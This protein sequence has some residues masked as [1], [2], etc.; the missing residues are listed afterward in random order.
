MATDLCTLDR[1]ALRRQ[2]HLSLA[3]QSKK[4][5]GSSLRP[6]EAHRECSDEIQFH[7]LF[8]C[9]MYISLPRPLPEHPM[10]QRLL[11]LKGNGPLPEVSCK[12]SQ[13]RL[14][15][16]ERTFVWLQT[17]VLRGWLCPCILGSICLLAGEACESGVSLSAMLGAAFDVGQ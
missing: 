15:D 1:M 12:S 9:S 8:S 5:R 10:G 13:P 16:T 2:K 17:N 11:K 4:Q 14:H 3:R 6:S 7:C